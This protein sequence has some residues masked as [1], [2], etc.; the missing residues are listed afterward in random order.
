MAKNIQRVK[1]PENS[2][3]GTELKLIYDENGNLIDVFLVFSVNC[4]NFTMNFKEIKDLL[5]FLDRHIGPIIDLL[6]V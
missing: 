3:W 1:G 6:E 5:N 2:S 4:Q